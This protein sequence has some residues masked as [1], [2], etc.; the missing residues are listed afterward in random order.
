MHKSLFY[1]QLIAITLAMFT[2]ETNAQSLKGK[3]WQSQ[4]ITDFNYEPSTIVANSDG[5]FRY[6][7]YK[8]VGEKL[9]GPMV[10][11][12]KITETKYNVKM[13]VYQG[14]NIIAIKSYTISWINNTEFILTEGIKKH[15][16]VELGTESDF[17]TPK[18]LLTLLKEKIE[19]DKP[20]DD[21]YSNLV[22]KLKG[23][24]KTDGQTLTSN[25]DSLK[26][27]SWQ[28]QNIIDLD[29]V[30]LLFTFSDN[31]YTLTEFVFKD[32]TK[33]IQKCNPS[34]GRF[35]VS[36]GRLCIKPTTGTVIPFTKLWEVVWLNEKS[37]TLVM[38]SK[39][40]TFSLLNSLDDKFSKK[41]LSSQ[42]NE[43]E[44]IKIKQD[45]A[46]LI[47]KSWKNV[48]YDKLTE[49][50][51]D[52]IFTFNE[53]GTL[54]YKYITESRNS[55]PDRID[56]EGTGTYKIV[57]DYIV[58]N[59][60]LRYDGPGGRKRETTTECRIG[61]LDSKKFLLKVINKKNRSQYYEPSSKFILQE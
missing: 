44:I 3:T 50:Y 41:Y 2:I 60:S 52:L 43:E 45:I 39:K 38:D 35:S 21:C 58:I 24:K 25:I 40:I 7:E 15:R 4:D 56:S 12:G 13:S 26:N 61:W 59:Y 8:Y 54:S 29:G 22:I 20:I 55:S 23:D 47:G 16:Y 30:P 51:L 53:N 9:F 37:F 33:V 31:S 36:N 5:T 57:N 14:A 17:F 19:L 42:K 11:E 6:L 27:K 1:Y 28:S 10:Y 32:S 46:A 49:V 34:E 18:F 48:E